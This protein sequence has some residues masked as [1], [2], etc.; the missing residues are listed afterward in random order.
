MEVKKPKKTV[1]TA[2]G[3]A[4][5]LFIGT[6]EFIYMMWMFS[7]EKPPRVLELIRSMGVTCNYIKD[8]VGR[9]KSNSQKK[10]KVARGK[11]IPMEKK[12]AVSLMGHKVNQFK[13]EPPRMP[14]SLMNSVR[15]GEEKSIKIKMPEARPTSSG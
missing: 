6:I 15:P 10:K 7:G 11:R 12:E 3:V 13:K 5:Y 8:A 2:V 14:A 1:K 9:I 4:A